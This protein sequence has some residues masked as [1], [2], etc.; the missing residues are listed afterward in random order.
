MPNAVTAIGM[1]EE[2]SLLGVGEE[3]TLRHLPPAY[4]ELPFWV[5]PETVEC[6][7]EGDAARTP[8]IQQNVILATPR[9]GLS[10]KNRQTR[11][12]MRFSASYLGKV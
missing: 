10:K 3:C 1:G 4:S 8:R 9:Q 7:D 12:R 6:C 5:L 11:K 2:R